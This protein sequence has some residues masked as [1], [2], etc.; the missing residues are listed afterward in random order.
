MDETK[1]IV[2]AKTKAPE[3]EKKEYKDETP[4]EVRG[5]MAE[6]PVKKL[7]LS[8]G[9]PMILS[10][11]LQALYNIVDSA[12]VAN[13]EGV[14]EQALNALT[15]AFPIQMLMVAVSIGTG[16]GVNA[17][18]SRSLGQGDRKRASLAAGNGLFLA[19]VIYIIFLLFAFVGVGPY[20]R[21]QSGNAQILEM[22]NQYLLVCC[23][24]SF[25]IIYFSIF[26]KVL[27]G[28]GRSLYSTIAQ[29][30]G[31]IA[32]II[33]DPV[34]IFGLLGFPKMGVTGAAL[35]TVVG[36][37]LSL[38]IALTFHLRLDKE[39]DN[40]LCFMKPSRRI[41]GQIYSIGLPAIISQALMSFMTYFLNI[42]FVGIGENVVTAYGLYYKI[43]QFILFAAFGLRDAITPIVSYSYG[44]GSKPRIK[45][46][47]S[48]G[49]RY[50]LTIMTAG[51]AALELFAGPIA[52]VFGLS[53]ETE[54]LCIAAIR[55][56]S[57]SFWFAGANVAFQGIFQALE[58]GMESL[59]ISVCRQLL[60][61]LP[62]AYALTRVIAA[63]S[64]PAS[65]V[66]ITF[67]IAE[68]ASC[69]IAYL[70]MRRVNRKRELA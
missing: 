14:G 41:I 36:Q 51:F 40:G 6:M 70:L 3:K 17:L 34:M 52:G 55:I 32:N 22:A 61:V 38:V 48:W 66:W 12:F 24:L 54:K 10:M 5:R 28:T 23:S 56:I 31:A 65:L 7:M 13:I 63:G 20:L 21:T 8:M 60:F 59:V 35:A 47:I 37:I 25:G 58:C 53:G 46:G 11:M 62:V 49:M 19:T 2:L 9:I 57:F 18:L 4:K 1:H 67:P 69:L 64:A 33:L 45:D 42:I 30:S 39:I 43:Q 16:V 26:E 44:M 27:Q 15:L 50:T 29:V 68:G